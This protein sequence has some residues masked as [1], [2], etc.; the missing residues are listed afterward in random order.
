MLK[1]QSMFRFK[2]CKGESAP[3]GS[4]NFTQAQVG[5][6]TFEAA[7]TFKYLGEV[8]GESGD[9]VDATSARIATAWK[10]FRQ[11]LPIIT[12]R[13]ISLTN[14]GNIFS[15]CIRK[16]LLYPSKQYIVNIC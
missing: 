12:N 15:S 6:D 2:K 7:P 10:S 1:K 5:K 4:S 13:G 11:L 8:I 3:T 9:C 16:S 14:L